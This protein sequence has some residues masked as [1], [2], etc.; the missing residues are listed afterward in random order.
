VDTKF[1]ID[2][3]DGDYSDEKYFRRLIR[4]IEVSQKYFLFF[5]AC[6]QIPRQNEL[7]AEIK[8]ELPT[9]NIEVIN[10]KEP[11]TDL[12]FELETIL[13]DKKPDA[14]FV[15]G[16]GNSI[17]SDGTG[18]ANNL[19]YAL[20]IS[21]DSFNDA[22]QCP[23]YLWLP[24]YAVI[25]ITR[26]APDFFSV[27]SGVFYFSSTAEQVISD[28]FQ[29]TSS[30]WL[31]VSSLPLAEKQKRIAMLESLLAEYQ[32]LQEEKRDKQA[33]MR[34][35]N[36]L[37]S[38]FCSI[39]EYRNA[40][41]YYEDALVIAR[42]LGNREGEG[43]C[44]SNL[45]TNYAQLNSYKIAVQYFE[46]ALD[47]AIQTSDRKSEA[48]RLGNLG[49]ALF[50]SGKIEEGVEI[51][52]KALEIANEIGDYRGEG[53]H[54]NNLAIAYNY[55]G[56]REKAIEYYEK[57]LNIAKNTANLHGEELNLGNLGVA[58]SNLGD[59]RKAAKYHK[60]ALHIAE[61]IGNRLDAAR[62][63][64]NLGSVYNLLGKKKEART[65]W[66]KSLDLFKT[67]ES[68]YAEVVSYNLTKIKK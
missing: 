32:G 15:Q 63:L 66:L 19:I 59:Y 31:E 39:S 23:I 50:S 56:L 13:A 16:L 67:I 17:S 25:K 64:N 11:I 33:E 20:N 6:N 68:N 35:Y 34:L 4:S 36:Q 8:S 29:N 43:D 28:I 51:I 49:F 9:K 22:F 5:V 42:E 65:Y 45:G 10:F 55:L 2:Q 3:K 26:H 57:S 52:E 46:M 41:S 7:I 18:D 60:K 40:I 37:A 54:L 62:H 1:A 27:R 44:L 14:I 53:G 58:Y 12:L 21:R 47:I 48:V 61:T 30:E 38:I 24:E